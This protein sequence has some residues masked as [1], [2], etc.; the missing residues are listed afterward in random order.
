[1]PL[2]FPETCTKRLKFD[3]PSP[4]EPAKPQ[5]QAS[6]ELS[7]L[8]E[9]LQGNIEDD[10]ENFDEQ[11]YNITRQRVFRRPLLGYDMVNVTNTEGD[12]VFLKLSLRPKGA[13]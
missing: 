4:P 1:M 13:L 9:R 8:R 11:H 7:E 6:K 3:D 5:S 12:R 2:Y 10:A